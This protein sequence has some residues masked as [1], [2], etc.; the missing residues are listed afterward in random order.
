MKSI[1]VGNGQQIEDVAIQE[2]G[3]QEG[4]VVLLSDN[5]LGLDDLLYPGQVLK[6]RNVVPELTSNNRVKQVT[7]ANERLE[8]NSGVVGEKP[9]EGYAAEDYFLE[10]Y[11]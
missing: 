7:I 9:N 10:D 3:C 5:G 4:V 6:V 11:N 1:I 2:Y 8:P